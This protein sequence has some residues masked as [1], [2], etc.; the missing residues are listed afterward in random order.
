MCGIM[1]ESGGTD[2]IIFGFGRRT[3]KNMGQRGPFECQNCH[4]LTY[5]TL[6]EQRV[7]FTLFFIPVIPY[8]TRRFLLC[9]ICS[10]GF[11]LSKEEFDKALASAPQQLGTVAPPRVTGQQPPQLPT[12]R[13]VTCPTPNCGEMVIVP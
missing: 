7:W 3:N 4:N 5:F 6:M 12:S 10:R 13:Q 8:E 9:G 2:L 1:R 11:K